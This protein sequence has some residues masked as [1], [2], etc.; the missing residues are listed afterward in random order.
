MLR[1]KGMTTNR[2]MAELGSAILGLDTKKVQLDDEG[3]IKNTNR[4]FID[5]IGSSNY[6]F[7]SIM[8]ED[9]SYGHVFESMMSLFSKHTFGKNWFWVIPKDITK[10]LNQKE[11]YLDLLSQAAMYYKIKAV[12]I[13]KRKSFMDTTEQVLLD[14]KTK[15]DIHV[16]NKG[17]AAFYIVDVKDSD[18]DIVIYESEPSKLRQV[19]Q[20]PELVNGFTEMYA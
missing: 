16:F 10:L 20:V 3:Y 7:E 18:V 19:F 12:P 1:T 6:N 4:C 17:L 15:Y 2:F 13:S 11:D 14:L 9:Q 8:S 5:M